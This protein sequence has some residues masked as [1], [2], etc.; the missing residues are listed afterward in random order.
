MKIIPLAEADMSVLEVA[1]AAWG[2][3]IGRRDDEDVSTLLSDYIGPRHCFTFSSGTAAF[4]CALKAMAAIRGG[5]EVI[6]PAYTACSLLQPVRRLGLKAVIVD[7]SEKDFNI[8]LTAAEQ[9]VGAD[10]LCIVGVHAFG[11]PCDA[12]GLLEVARRHGVF[13]V[14]DCAQALV[15]LSAQKARNPQSSFPDRPLR[16]IP[17]VCGKRHLLLPALALSL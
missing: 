9:A 11:L 12:A 7:I 13:L 6:L 5:T 8:S 17:E 14:E 3:A 10:T 4:Y 2:S 1:S 16:R 15:E